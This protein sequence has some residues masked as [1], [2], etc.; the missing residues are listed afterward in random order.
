VRRKACAAPHFEQLCPAGL[1]G[2]RLLS[3]R[4]QLGVAVA[5]VNAGVGVEG[6]IAGAVIVGEGVRPEPV[7]VHALEAGVTCARAVTRWIQRRPDLHPAT[8]RS[9]AAAA[10]RKG[11]QQS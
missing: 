6:Q 3:P 9:V 2:P 7:R 8:I 5:T 11:G 1:D 4:I 10:C